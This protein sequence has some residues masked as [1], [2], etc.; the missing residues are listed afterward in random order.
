MGVD[1]NVGESEPHGASFRLS[2]PVLR[3]QPPPILE[4]VQLG[5]AREA[6]F[7]G[8]GGDPA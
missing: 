6:S 7:G 2:F 8:A 3:N 5:M 1:I 4:S